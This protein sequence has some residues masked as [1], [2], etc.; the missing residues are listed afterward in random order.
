MTSNE[1][2]QLLD[3]LRHVRIAIIGDFCLDAYW[4]LDPAAGERSLETGLMTR[5]V[6]RQQYTLGGAGNIAMNLRAMEVRDVRAFGVVGNDPFGP[7]MLGMMQSNGIATSGMMMQES[8]WST[9]VYTKPHVGEREEQRIDFGDFNN[10]HDTTANALLKALEQSLPD[11]DAVIINEQVRSGIHASVTLRQRLE[12]LVASTPQK[13]FLL[14]SRH[15]GGAYPGSIKKLNDRE[16]A[17]LCGIN[18]PA[19]DLV[20]EEEARAAA[21]DLHRRWSLPVFV[22]RGERGC[23]VAEAH[24]LQAIPGMHIVGR[25]D[26][27]GAGDSMLAGIAAA[28]GAHRDCVTA[29]KLGNFVAGVTVQKLFKTGTASP[30][31]ILAIGAE[32]D[33]VY[34]ADLAEN[35]HTAKI[36]PGTD[37]EVVTALPPG[38]SFSHAIFDHDGTLSVLRQGWESIMEPLMVRSALGN[39]FTSADPALRAK[40]V[41]RIRE[42]IDKT[43]GVQTIAQMEGLVQI[44]RDL[45]IVP[46]QEILDAQGYKQLYDRE[47]DA[48]VHDRLGKFHRGELSVDD[49]TIKGAITFLTAMA[50]AGIMLFLASGSDQDD[51][52]RE[53]EALGYA[54]LFAGR[55]YGSIGVPEKDAKKIVLDRILT[56]VG[57]DSAGRLI[58]FG[59][60]PVEI[61]ETHKRGGYTM[62]IAT[63]EVRR[64]GLNPSKR[65]RLIRAGADL[66]VPDFSQH[67]KLLE[68]L[69]VAS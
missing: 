15:L 20:S 40:V 39:E 22:T 56:D 45:R 18:R 4:F 28:L 11:L 23:I 31:E 17:R 55:I 63:D 48:L 25:V 9:L 37:I 62:G 59:D 24:G 53:A 8:D 43:T 10:L 49:W 34:H 54:A 66:I 6:A 32:P 16:A 27:V 13:L 69:G 35:P 2:Q 64:F 19:D 14:D 26:P 44:V 29:A 52:Q 3:E 58:T 41:M 42:F 30:A 57:S 7:F 50:E 33:Y 12:H 5:P 46:T 1:L 67:R 21:S 51:V 61:R 47:L 38:A 36:L 65:A 68:L 60:G